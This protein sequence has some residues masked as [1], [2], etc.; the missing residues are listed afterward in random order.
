MPLPQRGRTPQLNNQSAPA[1]Q[2]VPP[3]QPVPAPQNLSFDFPD[4]EQGFT[5]DDTPTP[6]QPVPMQAEQ[7]YTTRRNQEL[8]PD[9]SRNPFAVPMQAPANNVGMPQA[10]GQRVPRPS[11]PF[12]PP[13]EDASSKAVPQAPE[14]KPQGQAPVD[15]VNIVDIPA[16]PP[17]PKTET[18]KKAVKPAV[19][20]AG[21]VNKEDAPAGGA[22]FGAVSVG[23]G[24]ASFAVLGIVF[25]F[26]YGVTSGN[27]GATK[28]IIGG[29]LLV[30]ALLGLVFAV[31]GLTKKGASKIASIVGIILSV[32][33]LGVV[34]YAY[35]QAPVI[36]SSFKQQAQSYLTDYITDNGA[37]LAKSVLQSIFGGDSSNEKHGKDATGNLTLDSGDSNTQQSDDNASI[38][39]TQQ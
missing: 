2:A 25:G 17:Q 27:W 3:Q 16:A 7:A 19:N 18:V 38:D 9:A 5:M 14:T 29:L 36:E 26:I 39:G 34:G 32:L 6:Q 11:Q 22:D 12:T 37:D 28:V 30:M 33:S 15:N 24:A 35:Y 10:P 23:L 20:N 4:D 13:V 31:F 21:N 8:Y 1:P